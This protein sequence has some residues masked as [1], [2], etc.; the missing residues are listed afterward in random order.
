MACH[1][2]CRSAT[3]RPVRRIALADVVCGDP[4][5]QPYGDDPGCA[6]TRA[7][8]LLVESCS[9]FG[10]SKNQ[11]CW[12]R[13]SE[14]GNRETGSTLS[15]LAHIFTRPGPKGDVER[16][17]R[18][19]ASPVAA[20]PGSAILEPIVATSRSGHAAISPRS[21][22]ERKRRLVEFMPHFAV[23]T[24]FAT[25]PTAAAGAA[26]SREGS[27]PLEAQTVG[28]S[29]A[30]EENAASRRPGPRAA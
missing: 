5:D 13:L 28:D 26:S 3:D 11:K 25:H 2:G 17:N 4:W 21:F 16:N 15:W 27:R 8:N 30:I 14:E 22:R 18:T 29:P 23:A 7:F 24:A 19:T 10:Q 6:K 20:T 12:R 9:Q 1:R